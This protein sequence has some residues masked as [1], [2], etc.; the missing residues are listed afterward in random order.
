MAGDGAH[1]VA[2]LRPSPFMPLPPSLEDKVPIALQGC[3]RDRPFIN[4]TSGTASVHH[5]AE[6]AA[7]IRDIILAFDGRDDVFVVLAHDGS[8]DWEG[9]IQWFPKEANNWMSEDWKA[10]VFWSFL[11][12]GNPAF[13]W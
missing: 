1:H 6:E 5:D 7:R 10:R 8:T 11:D 13:R 9:G 12:E 3:A 4:F 2:Q